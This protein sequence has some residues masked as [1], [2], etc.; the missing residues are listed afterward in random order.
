MGDNYMALDKD[1]LPDVLRLLGAGEDITPDSAIYV[2]RQLSH[3][4]VK[5]IPLNY[6]SCVIDYLSSALNLNSVSPELVQPLDRL[7]SD[8]H[9]SI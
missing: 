5:D 3:L 1:H 6:A 4:S 2:N 8:L 7:L 9:S